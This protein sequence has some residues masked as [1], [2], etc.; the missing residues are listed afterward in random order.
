MSLHHHS[1]TLALLL[2]LIYLDS[3]LLSFPLQDDIVL[4]LLVS[5]IRSLIVSIAIVIINVAFFESCLSQVRS[6]PQLDL[7]ISASISVQFFFETFTFTDSSTGSSTTSSPSSGSSTE[8][9]SSSPVSVA[10]MSV[11]KST[12]A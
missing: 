10:I 9:S 7:S 5:S 3:I 8:N 4:P 1:T 12:H 2:W 11:T 6:F